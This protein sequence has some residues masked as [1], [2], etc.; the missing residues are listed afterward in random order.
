MLTWKKLKNGIKNKKGKIIKFSPLE[1]SEVLGIS[2][3]TLYDYM[4]FLK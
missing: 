2:Y 4:F 3:K 1:A